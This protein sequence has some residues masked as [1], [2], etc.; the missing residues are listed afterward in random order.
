MIGAPIVGITSKLSEN[1]NVEVFKQ[2]IITSCHNTLAV[3]Q[4]ALQNHPDLE[5]IAVM[6][7]APRYDLRT[8]DPTGLKPKHVAFAN[9]TFAQ[10]LETSVFRDKIAIGKHSLECNGDLREAR[11]KDDRCNKYDG[12]HM[13]SSVEGRSFTR[14][15][16][17]I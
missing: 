4:P 7:H 9:T 13:Y 12:V 14:R 16:I 2:N 10:M 6:E 5:T 3:A 8:V 17:K 1:D 11:Y 15:M